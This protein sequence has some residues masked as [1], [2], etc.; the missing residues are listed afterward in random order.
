MP[1]SRSLNDPPDLPAVR[2]GRSLWRRTAEQVDRLGRLATVAKNAAGALAVIDPQG[3]V[4]WC[5]RAFHRLCQVKPGDLVDRPLPALLALLGVD[6]AALEAMRQTT[7][8][9]RGLQLALQRPA[10]D[11]GVQN[12]ALDLQPA[13]DQAGLPLGFVATLTDVTQQCTQQLRQEALLAALPNGVVMRTADGRVSDCNPTAELQ[14]QLSRAQLRGEEPYPEGW[15]TVHED[16]RLILLS[17]RP[18]L[19]ALATGARCRA[20]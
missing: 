18:A 16:L 2:A 19:R 13:L 17:K 9:G 20:P 6:A 8:Q 3:R 12:L 14:L 1:P 4:A 15:H 11:G 7:A 5:N 10:A